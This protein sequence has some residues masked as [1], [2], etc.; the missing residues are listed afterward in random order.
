[1]AMNDYEFKSILKEFLDYE[2]Y[3][4]MVIKEYVEKYYE[5]KT[6]NLKFFMEFAEMLPKDWR[7]VDATRKY[8]NARGAGLTPEM[9]LI[10]HKRLFFYYAETM[11]KNVV[12][13]DERYRDVYK[14]IMQP[15]IL[16]SD[17]EMELLSS[18]QQKSLIDYAS[19]SKIKKGRNYDFEMILP[20][21]VSFPSFE[22]YLNDKIAAEKNEQE[23]TYIGMNKPELTDLIENVNRNNKTKAGKKGGKKGRKIIINNTIKQKYKM[24]V[25][26]MFDTVTDAAKGVGLSRKQINIWLQKGWA[27][28]VHEDENGTICP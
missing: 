8:N 27:T 14:K 23:L 20:K 18:V 3:D 11:A 17:G 19:R 28:Y 10:T 25:G 7:V 5:K 13:D 6:V 2:D 26:K 21:Y 4:N 12:V 22:E 24:H 15:W 1:M 16:N 9:Y